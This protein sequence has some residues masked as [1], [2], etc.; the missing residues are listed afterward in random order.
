MNSLKYYQYAVFSFVVVGRARPP[1]SRR[2]EA[3]NHRNPYEFR[4]SIPNLKLEEMNWIQ[5]KIY[6]YNVTFGLYCGDY[7][8][9]FR[10]T[11]RYSVLQEVCLVRSKTIVTGRS[12]C[13]L[14]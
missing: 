1:F 9:V 5:R 4:V 13:R 14:V 12:K 6:L 8:N 2:S 11:I 7:I 10:S 3:Q